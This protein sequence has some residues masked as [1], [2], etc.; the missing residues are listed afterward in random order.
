MVYVESC[1]V[2]HKTFD[3]IQLV[4]YWL[5]Y[6]IPMLKSLARCVSLNRKD[7]GKIGISGNVP[8]DSATS[9]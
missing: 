4:E 5:T 6:R 1:D 9:Q 3:T 2:E 7:G 8:S